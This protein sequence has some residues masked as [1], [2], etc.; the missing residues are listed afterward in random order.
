MTHQ[1]TLEMFR[2]EARVAL[3]DPGIDLK[4]RKRL[5][6]MDEMDGDTQATDLYREAFVLNAVLGQCRPAAANRQMAWLRDAHC[7]AGTFEQYEALEALLADNLHGVSFGNHGFRTRNLCDA[8]PEA[9][10]DG[11][12]KIV[13]LLKG[14]GYHSFVNSGTLLGLIRDKGPI[15]H[16][17]DIDL[18]VMLNARGDADAA[19]EFKLLLAQLLAEGIEC[20]FAEGKNVIIKMPFIEGFEVDLFPAFGTFRRYN[21]FPYSRKQLTYSDVWPL[22]ECPVSGAPLPAKPERLLEENYGPGWR[23]PNPRFA[24][25]WV[26]QKKKFAALMAEC[27]KDM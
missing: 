25:P 21:I 5:M 27:N 12:N 16:D 17:D 26:A 7:K 20:H 22:K 4:P 9:L 8:K 2:D 19:E 18:A 24:F 23:I 15:P 13:A 11:I 14:L 10:F 1:D 3:R 6:E